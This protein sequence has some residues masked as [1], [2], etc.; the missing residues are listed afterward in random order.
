M[1]HPI[2]SAED[3]G[4]VI[5][6]V[7]KSTRVRQDD[8]AGT[9]QVSRQF[10]I[11]VERGKPTVQLGRVLLL[12]QELGIELNVEIPEDASRILSALKAR[13][14]QGQRSKRATVLRRGPVRVTLPAVPEATEKGAG[15]RAG[16]AD[17]ADVPSVD[18]TS[19]GSRT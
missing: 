2:H 14:G 8:L 11:D 6:A 15:A 18:G 17:A 10:A 3:L 19:G 9:V 5:R 1:K 4:L 7:R 13:E 12:L 16:D